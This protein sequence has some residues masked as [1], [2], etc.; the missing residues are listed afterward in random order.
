MDKEPENKP[1]PTIVKII[2]NNSK[3]EMT[4]YKDD[5]ELVETTIAWVTKKLRAVVD[6][7]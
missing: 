7:G 6:N 1:K 3:M 2:I 5:S 4:F